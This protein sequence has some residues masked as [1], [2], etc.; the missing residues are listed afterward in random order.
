LLLLL[1]D[2]DYL[3]PPLNHMTAADNELFVPWAIMT[4][5]RYALETLTFRA[6]V[7]SP[8][9]RKSNCRARDYGFFVDRFFHDGQLTYSICIIH[10]V[11]SVIFT[12]I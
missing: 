4:H 2:I 10:F 3:C 6:T 7:N 11:I 5:T 8:P 1:N 9:R 12:I